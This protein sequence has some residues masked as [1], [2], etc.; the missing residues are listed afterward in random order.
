ML[1]A[2][3]PVGH[4][5]ITNCAACPGCTVLVTDRTL[6]Q[7][8]VAVEGS[9]EVV[10]GLAEVVEGLAEVVEGSDEVVEGLAEVVEG[11][12]EVVEGLAEVTAGEMLGVGPGGGEL[13]DE[14]SVWHTPLVPAARTECTLARATAVVPTHSTAFHAKAANAVDPVRPPRRGTPGWDPS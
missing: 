14:D 5:S 2:E 10:E 7:S 13:G 6:M 3:P 8:W 9:D 11:A 4:T 12:D 1:L